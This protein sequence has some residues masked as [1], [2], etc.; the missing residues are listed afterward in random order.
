MLKLGTEIRE[1]FP[2][3]KRHASDDSFVY[4]DSAA[5]ALKPRQM[6]DAMHEY[7]ES[8]SVNIMRGIYPMSERATS[9]YDNARVAVQRLLHAPRAEEVVFVRNATE[10]LNLI[11]ASFG[12]LVLNEGDGVLLSEMEHH[13]NLIPWQQIAKQ[14]KCILH[15]LPVNVDTGELEWDEASFVS[16][17]KERKIKVV[18]LVHVSNVLGTINPIK[19][20]AALAH[21][22]GAY[23]AVDAA[24]SIVH[25]PID[26]TDLGVDFLVFSGHKLFGPTGIGVLW[27]R[28]ELLSRMP[29]YQTGGE[30]IMDVNLKTSTFQE[31][32]Y[33]FEAG[34][35]HI[36]GAIGLTAAIRYIESIGLD[37]VREHDKE[38]LA[39]A[40]ERLSAV[41][42]I[43]L[44]G[45]KDVERRSGAI[46]FVFDGIHP[47][48][49]GSF[50][51]ED[52][53]MIRVGDHCAKPLHKKFGVTASSRMSMSI[54]NDRDDI[55]MAIAA[56]K[57]MVKEFG[58]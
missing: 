42:G 55:D 27:A 38:M 1:D 24:Q 11:A 33:R 14:K 20:I 39:Y 45:P 52:G 44:W 31:P 48:D 41:K 54:Y 26:V 10:A 43:H 47:H 5:T 50:L 12:N 8:Y 22:A 30:M 25:M 19:K 51:A 4:L 7:Y 34:T 23:M 46:A 6:I 9:E 15:F 56:I 37:H 17:L 16:F 40:W 2:I 53:I 57:R 49:V 28:F 36:A 58:I 13:A 29:P 21:E 32:P 3:Y 35:P 18:S